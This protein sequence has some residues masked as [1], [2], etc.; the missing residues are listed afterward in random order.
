MPLR[1]S[2]S[3]DLEGVPEKQRIDTNGP[4]TQIGLFY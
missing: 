2:F 4:G 1:E 3:E